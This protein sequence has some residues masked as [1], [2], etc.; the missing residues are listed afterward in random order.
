MAD[1]ET[2]KR[3][4]ELVTDQLLDVSLREA[5][6]TAL[7]ATEGV[8]VTSAAIAANVML[9]AIDTVGPFIPFM[10][11]S[12]G[13]PAKKAVKSFLEFATQNPLRG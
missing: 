12:D 1:E 11:T 3:E 9:E 5:R 6:D 10:D 7:N 8:R 2:V 13:S 4:P